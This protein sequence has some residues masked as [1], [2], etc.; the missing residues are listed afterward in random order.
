MQWNSE[1]IFCEVPHFSKKLLKNLFIIKWLLPVKYNFL[2]LHASCLHLKAETQSSMKSIINFKIIHFNK[3]SMCFSVHLST[4]TKLYT[5]RIFQYILLK[6]NL[7]VYRTSQ[8]WT[9]DSIRK[10]TYQ[11]YL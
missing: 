9:L 1:L 4:T 7:C 11:F 10:G 8:A 5:L 2:P 6:Q 3:A